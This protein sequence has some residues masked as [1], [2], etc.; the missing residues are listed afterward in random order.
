MCLLF[1]LLGW[2]YD[3]EGPKADT[4]SELVSSLGVSIS[5]SK[6]ALGEIEVMN[7]EKRKKDLV[8]LI[9]NVLSKGSLQYKDGQVLN[10]KLAFAL[11][12]WSNFWI[13]W[14]ICSASCV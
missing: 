1:E 13:S 2:A 8:E 4:F 12:T 10:G 11:C 9:S 3:K 5:L 7:T 6:T 14:Q